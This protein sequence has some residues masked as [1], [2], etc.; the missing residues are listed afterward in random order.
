M[1]VHKTPVLAMAVFI[2]TNKGAPRKCLRLDSAI[3]HTLHKVGPQALVR[4]C[5]LELGPAGPSTNS[6]LS[7][8]KQRLSRGY[9]FE[10]VAFW[11]ANRPARV[12]GHLR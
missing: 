5:V 12:L 8:E 11:F 10:E 3:C 1:R 2:C 6:I 9:S 4:V 7:G